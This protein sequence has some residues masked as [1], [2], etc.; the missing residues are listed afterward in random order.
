MKF[1]GFKCSRKCAKWNSSVCPAVVT[2]MGA[3]NV[4]FSFFATAKLPVTR[5]VSLILINHLRGLIVTI[6]GRS[7]DM[8]YR[9]FGAKSIIN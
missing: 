2:K 6:K 5:L 3:L 8:S 4:R 7:F 9:S 1:S